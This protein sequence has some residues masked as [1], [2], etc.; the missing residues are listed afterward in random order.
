MPKIAEKYHA[1]SHGS[2]LESIL[3]LSSRRTSIV[4]FVN[5]DGKR[6]NTSVRNYSTLSKFISFRNESILEGFKT[7]YK[8]IIFT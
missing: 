6:L 4:I 5:C 2:R 1:W 7:Y 8:P 3:F